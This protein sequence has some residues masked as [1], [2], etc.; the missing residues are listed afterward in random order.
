MIAKKK[1]NKKK[2]HPCFEKYKIIAETAQEK[3]N[4]IQFYAKHLHPNQ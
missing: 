2:K 1:K 4:F 3:G